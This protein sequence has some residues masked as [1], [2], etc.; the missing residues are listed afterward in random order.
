MIS[1]E[2]AFF[3]D[4]I[5]TGQYGKLNITGFIPSNTLSFDRV[6]YTF[7]TYLVV[8][9]QT[10]QA[11][12]EPG[13]SIKTRNQS[14]VIEVDV[15]INLELRE[16]IPR[17]PIFLVI[18]MSYE[19]Q[20]YWLM[21]MKVRQWDIILYE[22]VYDI[23]Q[24]DSPNI[25]VQWHSPISGFFYWQ[26]EQDIDFVINLLQW[27]SRSLK[28][29]DDYIDPISLNTLLAHVD[30]WVEIQILTLPRHKA[31]F[32]AD[33]TLNTNFSCLEVKFSTAAHDRFVIINDSEYYH[34]WHS[35]K[36]VANT[37][38]SRFTKIIAQNEIE[39]LSKFFNDSWSNN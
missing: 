10:N 1:I 30:R 28:I 14:E 33:A 34:F 2:K 38:L 13:I 36:D 24:W 27:A 5:T 7:T 8:S 22:D 17:T 20:Q 29:F 25:N 23:V 39:E 21:E 11:L 26:D 12:N 16:E 6:P 35:L 37:K 3:C 9:G 32:T 18:P 31:L 15:N 4:H 19:V